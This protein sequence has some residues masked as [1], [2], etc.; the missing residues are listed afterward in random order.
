MIGM[1]EYPTKRD[2][3]TLLIHSGK[4]SLDSTWQWHIQSGRHCCCISVWNRSVEEELRDCRSRLSKA[5]FL[6]AEG[7]FCVCVT[8]LCRSLRVVLLESKALANESVRSF[9]SSMHT[10]IEWIT[11]RIR[12]VSDLDFCQ[13]GIALRTK[14]YRLRCEERQSLR[15]L[16]SDLPQS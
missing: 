9:I 7:R 2:P 14:G 12:G 10:D 5:D 6:V 4:L 3:T 16:L 15:D 1:E 8:E 13:F 11:A